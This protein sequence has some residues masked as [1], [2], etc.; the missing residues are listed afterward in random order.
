MFQER[1]REREGRVRE[2]WKKRKAR[3]VEKEWRGGRIKERI[4]KW[5]MTSTKFCQ[6][7]FGKAKEQLWPAW[8]GRDLI[9]IPFFNDS[10]MICQGAETQREEFRND[11]GRCCL[12]S[13]L[14]IKQRWS[15]R[16]SCCSFQCGAKSPGIFY[17]RLWFIELMPKMKKEALFMPGL[18]RSKHDRLLSNK[19]TGMRLLIELI[20]IEF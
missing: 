4:W 11:W 6:R 18:V 10:L 17:R 1:L 9:K 8:M 13:G 12:T 15:K 3:E 20:S 19:I 16:T 5:W 2:R 7:S 14:R